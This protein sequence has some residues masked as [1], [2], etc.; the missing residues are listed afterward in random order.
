MFATINLPGSSHFEYYGP[1][2]KSECEQWLETRVAELL[3]TNL[4]T[5]TL[6]RRIISN[7]EA[8]TWKYRDGSYVFNY[9]IGY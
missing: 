3:E 9:G 5:S 1:A 4:V 8:R 2:T 6:P 7:K